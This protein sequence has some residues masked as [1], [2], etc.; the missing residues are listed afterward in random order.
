MARLS[1]L[2]RSIDGGRLGFWCPGCDGMHAVTTGPHGWQYNG[3]PAMPTFRPSVLVTGTQKIS[4]DQADRILAGE[5]IEPVPL[6][7]HSFVT[8][9]RIQFLEDCTHHLAGKVADL[10]EVPE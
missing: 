8:D 7:C 6:R 4:Q 3:N 9:G 1:R 2:L 10:G 5:K